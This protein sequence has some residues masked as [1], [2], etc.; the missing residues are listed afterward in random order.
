[1]FL[2]GYLGVRVPFK[3]ADF[4]WSTLPSIKRLSLLQSVE[5]L[6]TAK[7][8]HPITPSSLPRG[9]STSKRSWTEIP[10]V[11]QASRLM[12]VSKD[13][14]LACL[15]NPWAN[16]LKE[17]SSICP[18]S[19]FPYHS[20]YL[21]IFVIKETFKH[22][23][24][25]RPPH[26]PYWVGLSHTSPALKAWV[27]QATSFQYWKPHLSPSQCCCAYIIAQECSYP[28]EIWQIYL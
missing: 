12:A 6:N 23:P 17:I 10:T 7:D 19:I 8:G 2:W 16:S 14:G 25:V 26:M 11:L 27:S 20:V 18:C 3:C 21:P 22:A 9:N 4:E 28:L 1:M 13:S 15:H 5:G 24:I